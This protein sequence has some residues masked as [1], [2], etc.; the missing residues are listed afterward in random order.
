MW[1]VVGFVVPAGIVFVGFILFAVC[2]V[3]F[4]GFMG[5]VFFAFAVLFVVF[6]FSF[7]FCLG[8][9]PVFVWLVALLFGFFGILLPPFCLNFTIVPVALLSLLAQLG[10]IGTPLPLALFLL[11]FRVVCI[12]VFFLVGMLSFPVVVAGFVPFVV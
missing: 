7:V 11:I 6:C 2:L 8:G 3:I 1:S 4:T 5:F 12:I 9:D 10:V